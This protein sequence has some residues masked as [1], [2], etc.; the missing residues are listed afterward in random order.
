MLKKQPKVLTKLKLFIKHANPS[1]FIIAAFKQIFKTFFAKVWINDL[2]RKLKKLDRL[3]V[4]TEKSKA[5]WP[6]LSNVVVIP[7]PLPFQVDKQVARY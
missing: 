7:D 1:E 6:E 3:V 2:T 4:L 5:L